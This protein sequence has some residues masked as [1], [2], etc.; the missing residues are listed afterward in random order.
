M[1]EELSQNQGQDE[2]QEQHN[3]QERGS[4]LPSGRAGV[5]RE[6]PPGS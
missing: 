4:A 3:E 2:E 1:E 5:R 6:K